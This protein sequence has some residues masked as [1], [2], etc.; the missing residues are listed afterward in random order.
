M[1]Q[2]MLDLGDQTR[3]SANRIMELAA[4]AKATD[5][6]TRFL[7]RDYPRTCHLFDNLFE[8]LTITREES[9]EVPGE[10]ISSRAKGNSS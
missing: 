4:A 10:A 8:D 5:A 6:R 2:R 3:A 7:Q 9:E 1:V